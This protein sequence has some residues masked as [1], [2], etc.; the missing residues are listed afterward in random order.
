MVLRCPHC[1]AALI[2]I[3]S[4]ETRVWLDLKGLRSLEVSPPG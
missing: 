1:D 2:R 4:S 3:V